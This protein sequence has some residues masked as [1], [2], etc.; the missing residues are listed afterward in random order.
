MKKK[1]IINF[2]CIFISILLIG[3][4]SGF[5]FNVI[6]ACGVTGLN[7]IA[8]PEQSKNLKL[9][10]LSSFLSKFGES[11][12][13][14]SHETGGDKSSADA[15]AL[16]VLKSGVVEEALNSYNKDRAIFIENYFMEKLEEMGGFYEYA[17][18][19]FN[20]N[21]E[22]TVPQATIRNAV[23]YDKDAPAIVRDVQNIVNGTEGE[24]F[25]NYVDIVPKYE[26]KQNYFNYSKKFKLNDSTYYFVINEL[27]YRQDSPKAYIEESYDTFLSNV[28]EEDYFID[29]G[30][31][32]SLPSSMKYFVIDNKTG[33]VT[34]NI[35]PDKAE[36]ESFVK[37]CDNYYLNVGGVVENKGFEAFIDN[38]NPEPFFTEEFDCYVTIDTTNAV[39]SDPFLIHESL[40]KDLNETNFQIQFIIAMLTAL[41]GIALLII[42]LVNSAEKRC[43]IDKLFTDVH[44]A[45][46]V[47]LGF[48]VV[49]MGIVVLDNNFEMLYNRFASY[50]IAIAALAVWALVCEFFMS[51]VRVCK[52]EKK[53][54]DNCLVVIVIKWVLKKIAGLFKVFVRLIKKAIDMLAYRPNE[55]QKTTIPMIIGVLII[56]AILGFILVL[57]L[58]WQSGYFLAFL[59]VIALIA[60]NVYAALIWIKYLISL[61]KIIVAAKERTE[62]EEDLE[63]LPQSL[64]TLQKSMKYTNLELQ[65]A[66]AKAVKDERLRT[67]LITNVSH[68]LKTPLTSIITYV[69][70]L[71]QCNL[72]DEKAKEYISVLDEKGLKLKRLI[73]DL[74]EASKVSSGNITLNLSELNLS[75]LVVQAVGEM[76]EEFEK[77]MLEIKLKLSENPPVVFADG[78]KTFRVIEN[79]LS[80]A[81]KYSAKGTR[82]YVSV[83]E[84]FGRGVFEIKNISASALDISADELTE[85]FVRGDKSRTNEGNGLGLS[86]AKELCSAMNG[87]LEL[88]I[89]GDLFKAKVY[90]PFKD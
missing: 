84:E 7:L 1:S 36:A 4:A 40:L 35:S 39:S 31:I 20:E 43:F 82:V 67:E 73:E 41:F 70:L 8:Y 81:K 65:E 29:E 17:G 66:V 21:A 18:E 12:Y 49:A 44:F 74:I 69:D 75:E 38:W 23:N 46:S 28:V 80:N 32:E 54:L 58:L 62:F 2:L 76:S 78:N 14:L 90:L 89:D 24:G 71:G 63:K 45:I 6:R 53:L 13:Q 3:S 50:V 9:T 27:T 15:N 26:L 25:L 22:Y 83:Y 11:L 77:N 87:K 16:S 64:K 56:D 68:D 57:S 52:S 19:Y 37:S 55:V 48:G 51:F 42:A 5:A 30:G 86:I 85:R 88:S 79:L 60:I 72:A 33:T 61:D 47:S 59:S 10:D 34:S